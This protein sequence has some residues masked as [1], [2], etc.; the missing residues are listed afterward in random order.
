M[1]VGPI[2]MREVDTTFE[3]EPVHVA[4]QRMHDRKVGTLVV[5]DE[6]QRPI[7][8]LTDRDL[9]VRVVARGTDAF[10]TTVG[11]AMTRGPRTV[12][13]TSPIESAL[14]A[15][16]AAAC[17]RLPVVDDDG[18][19]VGLLSLDD[20]LDLLAEEFG[21]IRTLLAAESPASLR[22]TPK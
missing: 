18:K 7:G 8:M 11:Q 21:Q 5:V 1:T 19:L 6:F 10:A 3:A 14:A 17:R 15:M 2:C 16:R 22:L 13:Q 9:A 12:L 4:A 20:I